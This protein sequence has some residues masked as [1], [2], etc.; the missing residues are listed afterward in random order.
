MGALPTSAAGSAFPQSAVATHKLRLIALAGKL[1]WLAEAAPCEKSEQ[2]TEKSVTA[3]R[4]YHSLPMNGACAMRFEVTVIS[5]LKSVFGA[6]CAGELG[7]IQPIWLSSR[8]TRCAGASRPFFGWN[9]NEY[10]PQRQSKGPFL[11]FL[12]RRKQG[13]AGKVDFDND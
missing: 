11:M 7:L 9:F 13:A 4:Q 2:L 5:F 12:Y 3:M 1:S 10:L 6:M 8:L